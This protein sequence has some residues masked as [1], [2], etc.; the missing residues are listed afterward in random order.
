M[1]LLDEANGIQCEIITRYLYDYSNFDVLFAVE[2]VVD[3]RAEKIKLQKYITVLSY[4]E[5][6]GCLTSEF[7]VT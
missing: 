7:V 2:F 5:F 3:N 6:E 1:K 4:A